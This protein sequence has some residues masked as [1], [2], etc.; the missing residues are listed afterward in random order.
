MENEKLVD[1]A[2]GTI[3]NFLNYILYHNVCPEHHSNILSAQAICDLARVEIWDA[4]QATR[5]APG[6]FNTACSTLFGGAHFGCY[7]GDQDWGP[8]VGSSG[9]PDDIARKIVKFAIVGAGT[10]EQALAFRERANFNDV[11]AERVGEDSTGFEVVQVV[12]LEEAT[13]EFYKQHAKDLKP[14]GKIRARKWSDPST[15][16]EDFPPSN[17]PRLLPPQHILIQ[18]YGI[19]RAINCQHAFE[20]VDPAVYF[21]D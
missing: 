4:L 17:I 5:L 3:R 14:V 6:D 13:V 21:P 20:K 9:L 7:T 1:M 10:G 15:A 2:T 16:P 12:P 18:Q 19:E 11:K 8:D